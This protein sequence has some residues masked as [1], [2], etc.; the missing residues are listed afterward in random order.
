M[1][2]LLQGDCRAVLATLDA[3]IV[4]TVVT[5]PRNKGQFKPGVHAYRQPLPHWERDWL[6]REYVE[7][8]RSSGEIASE[9][10]CTDENVLFWLRKHQIKRRTVSEARAL[11]HWGASGAANPMHGKTGS[12]NPRYVDGSSPERQRMYVQ[13]AGREFLRSILARDGHA[14]VRCKQPKAGRKSLHV[15]H[16][17]PWA[18]NPALRF[19][20][21]NVVTL[22]GSCHRFVH[23]KANV[24]RE[25]LP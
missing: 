20:P 14:C 11:K 25:H 2:K 15:H 3:E 9:I 1:I 10:G 7:R 6:V 24:A 8:Q 23:S 18:G 12:A 13:G 19:E 16:I 17:K 22:C 21:T 4:Q 5:S